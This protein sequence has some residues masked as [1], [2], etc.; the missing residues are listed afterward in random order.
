[1]QRVAIFGVGLIGGSFALA[2]R[3]AG[4]AGEIVGVSSPRTIEAAIAA[5]VIERGTDA[6]T[7]AKEC[8]LI[9]LSQ[10]VLG[11]LRGY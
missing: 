3:R 2:L 1:M 7:A 8:D 9:Y 11:I 10:P 5:G 4:F 6:V